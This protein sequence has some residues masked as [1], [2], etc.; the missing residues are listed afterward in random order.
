MDQTTFTFDKIT[1]DLTRHI[2]FSKG[3]KIWM[4]FLFAALIAC[5]YAY[6]IQLRKGLGVTG[7]RDYVSWGI[8]IANFVFFVASS[9]VGMLI[10]AALGLIGIKWVVPLT[11]I[12]ETIAVA[13]SA[14][15]GLVIVS[16]MG[17][18][19]RLAN[20]F[21]YGRFQ[22]PILWD[23]TVITTYFVISLL[24]LFIPMIP[25]LAICYKK[26]DKLPA[27]LRKTYQLLSL[28][29][30]GTIEQKKII[31]KSIKTLLVLIIPLA[32]SIHTVTSWLFAVNYRAGWDSTVFG[33]Y[34]VS[35]AFVAGTAAVIIAMYFFRKNY[36]LGDYLTEMHFNNMAKLLVLVA[37]VYLYFN[38]NE[39]MVPG[40]KMKRAD[41]I[42]IHELFT[43][44]FAI[45]FWSV[46][47]FG[48][49]IPIILLIIGKMRKP[50]PLTIIASFI[51][52]GAWL[53]R[54][55]IVVPTMEHPFLPV[56]HV[57]YEYK[58]YSPTIIEIAVTA[59]SFILVLMIITIISK[60]FPV[61]PIEETIEHTHKHIDKDSN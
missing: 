60:F 5:L 32:L 23:I 17:R 3:F 38:L 24:L 30:S 48:L 16:D 25:D 20:V 31:Q 46:Q 29:W 41:A 4:A 10:S 51:L 53:K 2:N 58:V 11:R 6:S 54:Y 8:Y 36:K 43:G 49:I 27:W 45:L 12:S 1:N 33:P 13:F 57:P 22:S 28:N 42:H 44:H 34:F 47:V 39:F 15:A 55:I 7:M 40:Y 26:L 9:L 52:I 61:I 50:L 37:L 18:P 56:Q 21:L 14:V 19:E 35:G 59:A